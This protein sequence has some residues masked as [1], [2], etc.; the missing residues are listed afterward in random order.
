MDSKEYRYED[1]VT[2]NIMIPI[3][4]KQDEGNYTY[5]VNLHDSEIDQTIM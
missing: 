4:S 2:I 1:C 5:S 3:D